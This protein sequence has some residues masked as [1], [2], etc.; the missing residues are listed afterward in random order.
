MQY[1]SVSFCVTLYNIVYTGQKGT[2]HN[3]ACPKISIKAL[4]KALKFRIVSTVAIYV[5]TGD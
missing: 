2:D 4:W 5:T 1:I 3:I